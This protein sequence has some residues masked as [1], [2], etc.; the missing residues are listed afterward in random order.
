[1]KK[2]EIEIFRE[3]FTEEHPYIEL[4]QM[5]DATLETF[6]LRDY[7]K[8]SSITMQIDFC[9]DFVMSQQMVDVQE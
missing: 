3:L 6:L 4:D 2:E 5:S 9:R 7:V 1:M 8:N